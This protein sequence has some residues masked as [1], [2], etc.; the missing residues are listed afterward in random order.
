MIVISHPQNARVTGASF[1]IGEATARLLQAF[2]RSVFAAPRR[3]DR[4][5]SLGEAGISTVCLG[6]ADEI[7]INA[8]FAEVVR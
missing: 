8:G 1:G 2:G 7:S 6:V 5:Q 3:T 4:M